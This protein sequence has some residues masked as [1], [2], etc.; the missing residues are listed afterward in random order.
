MKTKVTIEPGKENK[1]GMNG[2]VHTPRP[3]F[4]PHSQ[5]TVLYC[6]DCATYKIF[7]FDILGETEKYY[8]TPSRG[9]NKKLVGKQYFFEKEELLKTVIFNAEEDVRICAYNYNRAKEILAKIRSKI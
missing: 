6:Y 8:S 4:T 9:I 1:G 7:A 3:D 5:G 2:V